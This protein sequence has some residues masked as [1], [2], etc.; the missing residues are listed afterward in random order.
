MNLFD[1]LVTEA[2]KNQPNLTSLRI[3]VEKELLHHDILRTLSQNNLL[4]DLTFIDGTCLRACYGGIRLSEDLDFTGGKNF[5]RD[6]L[7]TMGQTLVD[8]LCDKYGLKVSVSDPVKDIK[9][10][11]TWKIKIDTRPQ[12]KHLPAQRIN[13]DICAI[14]SYE[15]KP[16]MLLNPYGVDMGTGGLI[17]QVQSR[18][19]IYADKL[20][21]FALRPNRLKCRDLWDMVWL[22][23]QGIKPRFELIPNKLR[24]RRIASEYFLNLFGERFFLLSED[25]HL[26]LEFKKEM[27]RFLSI[28]QIKKIVDQNNLWSF[29]IHLIND[30]NTEMR[31][32][33]F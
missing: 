8:D 1:E 7:L 28:E 26:Q 20:L 21:A 32:H 12:Q 25:K 29:I 31:I 27:Q 17:L 6:H 33:I 2:L 14:T 22:H 11:D 5:S 3:V 13:I 4:A 18:E 30:L 24:D 15:K 10:V 9:N 23:Q 19:E 16:M